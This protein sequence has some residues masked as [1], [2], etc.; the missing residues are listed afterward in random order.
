MCGRSVRTREA[1]HYT[2]KGIDL[3]DQDAFSNTTNRRIA[4]H[5]ANSINFLRQKQRPSAG[6]CC[7]SRGLASCMA[8]SNDA[9]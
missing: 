2:V 5:F 9:D 3:P 8:T 6:S 1:A 4:R 7:A